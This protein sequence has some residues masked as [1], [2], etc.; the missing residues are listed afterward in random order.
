[1]ILHSTEEVERARANVKRFGWARA[2]AD[3]AVAASRPFVERTDDE[4]W[5][6]VTG[7]QV[8]RGI[9]VNPEKG[10]P[11]CGRRVY[12]EHGNYPWI[13]DFNKPFK[14]ECPSCQEIWPKNDFS[15][16]HNSG[17]GPGG[18]FD[19]EHADRSLLFNE[20]H[21][22]PDNP[23]HGYAVDDGRGWVDEDGQRWW[24]IAFFGHYGTWT[25]LPKAVTAL[26]QAWLYT[27]DRCYAHK[28]LVLLDRIADVYPD[29]DLRPWSDMVLYNSHGGTGEGRLQ[30]CI[31]ETFISEGLSRAADILLDAVDGDTALAEFLRSKAQQWEMANDKASAERIRDNIRDGLLRQFIGSVR[32]FRIRGNEGMTQT[33][34]AAAAAV[35]D[36]PKETPAAL[37]W[38]YEPG[39]RRVGG[40]HIP[41][42][43][44]GE[45]DR[46]G[47]GSEASPSYSFLWMNLFRR[48]AAVL[49]RCQQHRNF[50]LHRD[51]PRLRRM[52]AAPHRLTALDMYSPRI[53]DTGRAGDPGLISVDLETT[54]DVFER[55][56]ETWAAQLAFRLNGDSVEGL[57]TSIFAVEPEA[58]QARIASVVKREGPLNLPSANLNGY[59]LAMF[60]HGEGDERRAAWLYYGRNTGHGHRDRL[61]YGLYYRGMDLLPEMGYPEYA[62]GMWPKRAGWTIN[63]ISHN[64]VVVNQRAQDNSWVGR[65]RLFAAV[66]GASVVEVGC[67]EVY[68]EASDY[69]RTLAKVDVSASESYLVDVFRVVG[70]DHHVLSFHSGD[71]T[72]TIEGLELQPQKE[73]TYAGT[74]ISF[75]EHYDG[76]PDGRYCGS[77]FSYLRNVER[78]TRPSPG[79][80]VDWELADTWNVKQVTDDVHLRYHGLSPA[81]EVSLA[82]GEPPNNKPG[83]PKQLRFLL[84]QNKG[85]NLRSTFVGVVEPYSG[86]QRTLQSVQRLPLTVDS[87]AAVR[88]Q[89]THGRTDIVLSSDNT[90]MDIELGDG[91]SAAARFVWVGRER[92]GTTEILLLGGSHVRLPEGELKLS[93]SAY[94]GVIRDFAQDEVGATWLDVEA[95]LPTDGRLHGAQLRVLGTSPRDTCYKIEGVSATGAELLRL[96]LGD[97]TLVRGF[98][99]N[100]DYDAGV[101]YDVAPGDSIEILSLVHCRVRHGHCEVLQ[102]NIDSIWSPAGAS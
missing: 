44:I 85:Q 33:A 62:D 37:D 84:Q 72:V 77:G 43:L 97:T 78:R 1:M 3:A 58:V 40:G 89:T 14:I 95:E 11:S 54:I 31:W 38:L 68:P 39:A 102:A 69:R 35:L 100:Q 66:E 83:N 99:D 10:C 98:V 55:F 16:W 71:G 79:W 60:R 26:S 46:D 64:T 22:D 56:G 92:D 45:V 81:G 53:G 2:L 80:S 74:E 13:L 27:G 4:L 24:F 86:Q 67:A 88:I 8:P 93:Q 49:E 36:D 47:V 90:D 29:M 41:A 82:Y 96:D 23:L 34:M 20:E 6:L 48:C 15:A 32:D 52:Y 70:G 42:T 19:P 65:C 94:H 101:L 91:V 28:G 76:E 18:V 57:H 73:G 9:H 51:F 75:G 59:G 87:A 63:T 12:E 5:A 7:Q 61:N 17:L 25:E 21:P 50:D 30:G